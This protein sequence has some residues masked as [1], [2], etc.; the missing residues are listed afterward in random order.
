MCDAALPK[1]ALVPDGIADGLASYA[2]FHKCTTAN[3]VWYDQISY[4]IERCVACQHFTHETSGAL[5]VEVLA[6]A[7]VE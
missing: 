4:S 6:G 1:A 3:M 7:D 5:A 2:R